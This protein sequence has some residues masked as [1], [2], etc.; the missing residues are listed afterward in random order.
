MADALHEKLCAKL[1]GDAALKALVV[2]RIFPL[3]TP[4]N[5]E[6]PLLTYREISGVIDHDL[7]G[8]SGL[9]EARLQ[10]DAYAERYRDIIGI[11]Q[12]LDALLDNFRGDLDGQEIQD[13][14]LSFPSQD[15]DREGESIL[16]HQVIELN[17]SYIA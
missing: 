6:R 16:F 4:K 1:K 13:L 5:T 10:L 3:A 2:D 9:R 11:R 17:V 12:A 15:H 14:R 7:D 8:P